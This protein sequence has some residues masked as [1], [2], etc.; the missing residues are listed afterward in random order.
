MN[1]PYKIPDA[2]Q[3]VVSVTIVSDEAETYSRFSKGR[4]AQTLFLRRSM[5]SLQPRIGQQRRS[6][7]DRYFTVEHAVDCEEAFASRLY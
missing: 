4:A 7:R 2:G 3:P 6:S 1:A 5:K